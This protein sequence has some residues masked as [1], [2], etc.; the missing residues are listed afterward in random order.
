MPSYEDACKFC[1]NQNDKYELDG[2]DPNGYCGVMWN[3]GMH[4]R[5]YQVQFNSFYCC[6]RQK[7]YKLWKANNGFTSYKRC[8][9]MIM[10][11]FFCEVLT[12][13]SS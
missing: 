10:L 11:I 8:W 7:E 9:Q 6:I 13:Y 12:C 1:I 4:D 2:R 3:F 5:P